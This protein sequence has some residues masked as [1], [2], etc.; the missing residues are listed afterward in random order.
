MLYSTHVER[1]VQNVL[2]SEVSSGSVKLDKM[3][4]NMLEVVANVFG[5]IQQEARF[6]QIVGTTLWMH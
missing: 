4:R 1:S 6:L 5:H 3:L 2:T